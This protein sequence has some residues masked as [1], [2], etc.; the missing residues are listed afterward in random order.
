MFFS[1]LL[2]PN[3]KISR[4]IAICICVLAIPG[5]SQAQEKKQDEFN[6]SLQQ[7]LDYAYSHQTSMQNAKLDE[8]IAKEKVREITG[9]GLPQLSGSADL[10]YYLK[11]PTQ[12]IPGTFLGK[13]K[14]VLIPTQF[15]VPYNSTIGLSLSQ[16]VFDGSYIVGLQASKVYVDLAK[17]ATE[18]TRVGIT[19]NVSKAYYNA[20]IA[21][22]RK[23]LLNASMISLQKFYSDMKAMNEQGLVEKLDV[24]R[25]AVQINNLKAQT[26]SVENMISLSYYALK[27][28]MGMP[29]NAKIMLTDTVVQNNFAALSD[30]KIDYSKRA[31]YQLLA[32]QKELGALDVKRYKATYL[33]SVAAFGT[34]NNGAQRLKFDIFDFS[35]PWYR[36]SL[37]G[38]KLTM[39]IFDGFQKDARIKQAKYAL[40]KTNNSINDFQNT[41]DMDVSMAKVN[42]ENGLINLE[43]AKQ[44]LQLAEDVARV[45]RIKYQQGVGTN[46]EVVNAESSLL[47][48]QTDYFNALLSLAVTRIDYQRATGT[49]MK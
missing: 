22:K 27:Y 49:L 5:L 24:D 3:P 4:T 30:E 42:Y 25:I 6:F 9:L 35:Q 38:I 21:E 17:K 11:V 40:Q 39:P 28:Q 32:K 12:V 8:S 1:R 36:S 13:P 14:D 43:T 15:G 48:S 2:K 18:V 10:N 37:I 19:A 44:N 41:I 45:T 7:A 47:T 29:V 33:P 26:Q 31:E 20:I 16:L 23:T 46:L 34:L